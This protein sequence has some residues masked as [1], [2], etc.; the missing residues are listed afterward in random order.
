M[1]G[2]D[3]LPGSAQKETSSLTRAKHLGVPTLKGTVAAEKKGTGPT[4]RVGVSGGD[5][6]SSAG[7]PGPTESGNETLY[8]LQASDL[9]CVPPASWL[10]GLT[11]L[12]CQRANEGPD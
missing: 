11:L 3:L 12:I 7:C 8:Q 4:E 2:N 9:K 1:T 6:P 10:D 5:G